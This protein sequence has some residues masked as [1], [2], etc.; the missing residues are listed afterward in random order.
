M[1]FRYRRRRS[2]SFKELN[3]ENEVSLFM[4]L[5]AA[6]NVLLWRYTGQEDLLVGTDGR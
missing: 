6:F 4:L 2:S 3:R 5:L 1:R